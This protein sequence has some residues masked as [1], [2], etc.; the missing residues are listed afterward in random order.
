M[1]YAFLDRTPGNP[2]FTPQH[3]AFRHLAPQAVHLLFP[4]TV[5]AVPPAPCYQVSIHFVILLFSAPGYFRIVR[6]NSPSPFAEISLFYS[7]RL[8]MI[9]ILVSSSSSFL[10][11]S[12]KVTAWE[13]PQRI[14]YMLGIRI[15]Y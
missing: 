4:S 14:L 12:C 6:R 9:T 5:T 8:N 2:A 7:T 3:V 13:I 11:V 1:L 10:S 15:K